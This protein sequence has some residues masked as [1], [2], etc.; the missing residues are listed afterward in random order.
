MLAAIVV[1]A[2]GCSTLSRLRDDV[3]E[4]HD[5]QAHDARGLGP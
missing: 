3:L 1:A 5:E 4:Q 2:L